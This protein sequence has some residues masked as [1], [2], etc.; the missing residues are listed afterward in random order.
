MS[1]SSPQRVPR[2]ATARP[3][4]PQPTPPGPEPPAVPS[5]E[6]TL[7]PV[8]EQ[9]AE[10]LKTDTNLITVPVIAVTNEGNYVPDLRQ[11]EFNISEDGAPQEVAFFA[12]VSAPFHVILMLDTS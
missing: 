7:E 9:E 5:P 10:T 2:K 1:Q 12:T 4:T 11:E 8:E 6:P 3:P